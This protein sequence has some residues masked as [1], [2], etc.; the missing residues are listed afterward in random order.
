MKDNV[1]RQIYNLIEKLF[2]INRSLTGNGNRKSLKILN[3]VCKNLKILEFKSGSKVYDWNIP[4]EWNVKDAYIEYN[5]KKIID[6]KKNNLHLVSYS[7][8]INKTLSYKELDKNLYSIKEKPKAIPYVTS[9]YKK[10]WGFSLKDETRKNLKK[11]GKYKVYIDSSF[12]KTGSLSIG[13]ILIK[14]KVKQE[15]ILSTNIC[16]PSMVNNELCAPAILSF[17]SK[18]FKKKNNHYSIRILFLPE[19]VGCIAYL[20]NNLK[21]LKKNFRAGYHISCFG[22][23]GKFSIVNTKYENSYS[24]YVASK[25]LKNYGSFKKYPFKYCGSDERQYNFPGINLPLATLTRTKFGNFSEYHSSLDNLKITNAKTLKQSFNL[26]KNL[27]NEINKDQALKVKNYTVIGKKFIGNNH[28]NKNYN[29]KVHSLTKCEPFLSKR[30]LYRD[31]S[32]DGL[33]KN[34]WIM[35]NILYY[36]DGIKIADVSKILKEKNS[37]VLLIAKTLEKNHLIQ[38]RH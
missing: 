27:I 36:G 21:K 10:R 26:L 8:P 22:D 13:E 16:H 35:F 19:T 30:N 11:N 4:D 33:T 32:K 31:L 2:P 18:H 15:I 12:K 34:E 20:K 29:L 3:S 9:Y 7:A 6:F 14:G 17:I 1:G 28:K 25:V 38:L 23:K 37:K 5:K 24:D